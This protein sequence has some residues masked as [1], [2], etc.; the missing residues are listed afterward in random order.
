MGGAPPQG[1]Y[2][3]YGG[4][5]PGGMP[6]YGAPPP[7]VNDPM[8]GYF[9]AIAGQVGAGFAF[10]FAFQACGEGGVRSVFICGNDLNEYLA[11][12]W[13]RGFKALPEL[14]VVD[15]F[16]IM[17]CCLHYVACPVHTLSFLYACGY[18]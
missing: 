11:D 10:T 14:V 7:A 8:W 9:T 15:R 17:F 4:G 3:P 13:L 16:S 1:G 6:G 2:A 5:F 12:A 18:L